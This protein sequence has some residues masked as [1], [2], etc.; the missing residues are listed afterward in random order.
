MAPDSQGNT[1]ET[2]DPK[3]KA[4]SNKNITEY[5]TNFQK[6]V[7]EFWQALKEVYNFY[8]NKDAL[9]MPVDDGLGSLKECP[10]LSSQKIQPGGKPSCCFF[11]LLCDKLWG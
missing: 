4:W 7:A 6:R 1:D 2:L 9:E 10:L 5:I 3:G 8:Y 11:Y